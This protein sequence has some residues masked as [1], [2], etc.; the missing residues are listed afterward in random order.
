[1]C[2]YPK[3]LEEPAANH[4]GISP[5]NCWEHNNKRHLIR[6]VPPVPDLWT[7]FVHSP[8]VC[9]E[10]VSARNRVLGVVPG[11]RLDS[12]RDLRR[13]AKHL[14]MRAGHRVPLTLEEVLET[15]IGTRR[16][17]Y[18]DAY[19]SLLVNPLS[20]ADG[21]IQ[22]FVKAEKINPLDK[23]NPDPRM[24]QARSPR[25][26]L[27]IAQYLRPVEHIIYNLEDNFGYRLV[28]KGLNQRDR[29]SAIVSRFAQF[30]NPVC[31]SI[32]CSRWDK[33]V[34]SHVLKI[35]HDFYKHILGNHPIFDR[36][37][38]M[39]VNNKCRT[40]GG[41]KYSVYGGRMSGD[42]NTALGNCLLM[43]LMVRTAMK[44]LGVN[45]YSF[46]DDGDDCLV[47]VEEGDFDAVS[48]GLKVEFLGFGQEL[49]IENVAREVHE[50]LFCQSRIVYNGEYNIMVRDWRKVLS[51][52]CCGTRHWN[53]P[54]EVRPM[55]GLIGSCELALNAGVPILQAFSECLIRLSQGRCARIDN[56]DAGILYRVKNEF[57]TY[58]ALLSD[59][60][61]GVITGRPITDDARDAFER[62]FGVPHWQQR[63][64]EAILQRWETS[65]VA[66]DVPTE[67]D[68]RWEDLRSLEVIGPKIF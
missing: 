49:K 38:R 17:R 51:H 59:I 10:I 61:A 48:K 27:V 36:L 31:F 7:C 2:A 5:P 33:H 34:N 11:P 45:M 68:H 56:A 52:A 9:N 42:I 24:I 12:L 53:D 43:V 41:V 55:F 63:A 39:Q 15:F 32:D 40:A 62:A 50:V 29:A 57:G 8:C 30:D 23:E 19:D 21:R 60:K 18:Q 46:L 47:F 6:F 3:K 66:S 28:A 64:V 26:N 67:W 37:L 44:R 54:N 58:D 1:V 16:R 4:G 20:E 25:Y 35:E 13:E 65:V 22:S 14:A